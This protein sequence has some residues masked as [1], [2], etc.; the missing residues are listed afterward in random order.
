MKARNHMLQ[1]A[2]EIGAAL[3]APFDPEDVHFKPQAV[4]GNRALAIAYTNARAIQDRLDEVLGVDGWEDEYSCLPDGS[5]VCR[6]RLRIAGEWIDKMDVGSPSEQPDAGDKLKAAF[7]D[8]LKRAA[9]KFGIGRYLH[10]LPPQ[11][12]DYDPKK[13]QFLGKP[14]LPAWALP[15]AKPAPAPATSSKEARTLP[16]AGTELARR[17]DAFDLKLSKEGLCMQG[18]LVAYVVGQVARAGFDG[19]IFG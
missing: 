12:I 15:S 16:A 8:A 4:S 9:V 7:S 17:L 2:E 13:R 19:D 14:Q 3:A 11:W 1:S 5:V 18:D 10:Q 6:L